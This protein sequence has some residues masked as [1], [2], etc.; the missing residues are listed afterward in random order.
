MASAV[1]G[2]GLYLLDMAGMVSL[3]LSRIFTLTPAA[4]VYVIVSLATKPRQTVE[5]SI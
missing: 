3:P 4:I 2:I 5:A 1:A